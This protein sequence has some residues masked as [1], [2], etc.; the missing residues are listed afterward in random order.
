MMFSGIMYLFWFTKIRDP[1]VYCYSFRARTS[2]ANYQTTQPHPTTDLSRNQLTIPTNQP[3][4][5]LTS[6]TNQPANKPT[7]QSPHRTKP[8]ERL[9]GQR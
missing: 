1:A 2:Q 7:N 6:H 5:R 3:I 4:N 9:K 8:T